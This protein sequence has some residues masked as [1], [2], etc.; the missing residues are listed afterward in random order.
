LSR[1]GPNWTTPRSYLLY[2]CMFLSLSLFY[3]AP[4]IIKKIWKKIPQRFGVLLLR[5]HSKFS[6]KTHSSVLLSILC[7]RLWSFLFDGLVNFG[8]LRWDLKFTSITI[9]SS[10][11]TILFCY[12]FGLQSLQFSIMLGCPSLHFLHNI[13][14]SSLFFITFFHF[15]I[16]IIH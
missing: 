11:N 8:S 15:F 1:C 7:T 13:F 16:I 10:H 9:Y 3:S 6:R 12:I 14:V 5:W 2:F 4:I